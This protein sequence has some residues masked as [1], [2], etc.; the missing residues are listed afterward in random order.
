MP[1]LFP[2]NSA[3]T[4]F[5]PHL[6]TR[7]DRLLTG[8]IT[9]KIDMTP[10]RPLFPH[11]NASIGLSDPS[12]TEGDIVP[13]DLTQGLGESCPTDMVLPH[14]H[15]RAPTPALP[16]T[17]TAMAHI[18]PRAAVLKIVDRF[19]GTRVYVARQP[20]ADN[21]LAQLIG[22]SAARLLGGHYG[23]E[24]VEVPRASALRR[25]LRNH[26]MQRLRESGYSLAKLA[27]KYCMT[28]RQVRRI[29]GLARGPAVKGTK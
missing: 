24:F 18:I 21:E 14:S 16:E 4:P 20:G 19:G 22:L 7:H 27:R 10:N 5:K 6:K 25:A 1:G 23:G 9:S 28:Q 3:R 11:D 8:N 17:L 13:R 29:L 15:N 26:E 12:A 2:S